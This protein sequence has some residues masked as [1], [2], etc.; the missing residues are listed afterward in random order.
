M[1]TQTKWYDG[2]FNP[3][4]LLTELWALSD[5]QPRPDSLG[6]LQG[7]VRLDYDPARKEPGLL[8]TVPADADL[9]RIDAVMKAHDPT[10]VPPLPDPR[11]K[12]AKA[13]EQ[14][15][16]L[17]QVKVALAAFIRGG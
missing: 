17:V 13:I 10:P 5:L 11:E 9:K 12:H 16:T 15:A 7:A 14:A 3:S 6:N 8:V 1:D 4:R 2:D